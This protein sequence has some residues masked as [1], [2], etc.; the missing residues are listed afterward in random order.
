MTS[1]PSQTESTRG[2]RLAAGR[3][4]AACQQAFSR[5]VSSAL[6]AGLALAG[7]PAAPTRQRVARQDLVKRR[8]ASDAEITKTLR[9]RLGQ[10]LERTKVKYDQYVAGETKAPPVF[11]ILIISGGGDWGAFGAG[12]LK[13]WQRIPA[14][15]PLAM[16]EFDVVT[17]VSTGT[18]IAPF[19]FLGDTQSIDSIAKLYRNPGADWVK[20]RGRLYFLPDNISFA[21]VPGLEREVR[22]HL[23][24]DMIRRIAEA[25][26]DGRF[27]FIN[28]TNLDYAASHPFD[29]VAEARHAVELGELDRIH[30]IALAS[31]GIPAA[32]PFRMIDEGLHVDGGVTANIIYGG[33]AAEEDM[34]PGIWQT[35]YPGLPIPKMRF[36]V[37]FN[38]QFRPPPMVTQPK[39]TAVIQRSLET[40][41]RASTTTALH[42]LFSMAEIARFKRKADMEV[43]VVSI[44]EDWMPPAPGAFVKETM[45][46]LVE[47]GERLGENPES[48]S[49]KP[50]PRV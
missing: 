29:L 8:R 4:L 37:I 1:G 23:N 5:T 3:G 6:G 36:W 31:A 44:P 46:E 21:E 12:Y 17:G 13:G 32:F 2:Q 24:M 30:N 40:G 47:L 45:N 19:A 22:N 26:A 18:L 14:V 33:Q 43:R 35:T 41:T 27:L 25:G 15:H 7:Y 48:W 39:W 42:H 9:V 50:P 49:D 16:P 38:N 11:N 34:P 10:A 28:T 20:P